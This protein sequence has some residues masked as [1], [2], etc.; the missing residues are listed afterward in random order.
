MI[1]H[2]TSMTTIWSSTTLGRSHDEILKQLRDKHAESIEDSDEGPLFW[3]AVARAQ[4]ECGALSA[5]VLKKIEA[6]VREGRG[7]ERWED[8]GPKAAERR[9]RVLEK[10][11]D[12]LRTKNPRPRKR[13]KPTQRKPLFEPGD[14]LAIRLSDG[15]YAAAIV[16]HNPPEEQSPGGE[17]Y[18]INLIGQLHYKSARKPPQAVFEKRKW[19]VPDWSSKELFIVN[20]MALRFRA[21][22]ER[23]EVVGKTQLRA[24]D[25]TESMGYTGWDFADQMM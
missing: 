13:K 19:L 1:L 9:R 24:D 15:S 23:F 21:F 6:I 18:G 14:C 4:W 8:T 10:F 16:L 2:A 17:T 22:K 25:P 11:L 12:T 5:M 20:V 7:L 3:L